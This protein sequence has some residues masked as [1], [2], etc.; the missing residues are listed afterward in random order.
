M[1][2]SELWGRMSEVAQEAERLRAR[3]RVLESAIRRAIP[4]A[5]HAIDRVDQPSMRR[6]LTQTVQD[7]ATTL[8][9]D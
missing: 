7:L 2:A 5:H 9:A 6:S 3:V 1:T 4:V 8:E